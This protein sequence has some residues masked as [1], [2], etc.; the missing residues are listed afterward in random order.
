MRDSTHTA[1]AQL[2]RAYVSDQLYLDRRA[3]AAIG[4]EFWIAV[5]GQLIRSGTPHRVE[6]RK[7]ARP[8][9]IGRR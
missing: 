9:L 8:A 5:A 2:A 6:R 1:L 4:D 3:G 7:V